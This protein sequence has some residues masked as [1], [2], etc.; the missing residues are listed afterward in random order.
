MR[1]AGHRSRNAGRGSRNA[2]RGP[3]MP[4]SWKKMRSLI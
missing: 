2:G 1:A 4:V 3:E